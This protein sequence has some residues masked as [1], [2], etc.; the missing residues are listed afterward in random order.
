MHRCLA[1]KKM[2]SALSSAIPLSLSGTY[3]ASATSFI[4]VAIA[5]TVNVSRL[6]LARLHIVLGDSIVLLSGV[7]PF[8]PE[9]S[10][11]VIIHCGVMTA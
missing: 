2:H 3:V 5:H 4:I 8:G 7:S 9:F 1:Y 10:A 11:F 6:L